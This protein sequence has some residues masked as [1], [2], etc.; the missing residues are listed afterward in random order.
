MGLFQKLKSGLAK[1]R[2]RLAGGLRTVLTLGRSIDDDLLEELEESLLL[3]DVGPAATED[4]LDALRA[5]WKEGK[6]STAD[7]VIP[8]LK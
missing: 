4:L 8:F 1:T 7:D 3:A 5:A 6:L 2:D